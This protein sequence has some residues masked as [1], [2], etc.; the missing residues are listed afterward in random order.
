MGHAV[1]IKALPEASYELRAVIGADEA[2][3]FWQP[4]TQRV[5]GDGSLLAGLGGGEGDS[6]AVVRVDEGE[7]AAAQ[8]IAQAHHGIA[9]KHFKQLMLEAFGFAGDGFA[10]AA[11][12]QSGGGVAHF[13]WIAGDNAADGGDAGQCDV[14]C[15][16]QGRSKTCS[17][18]LPRL[19]NCSRSWRI[20]LASIGAVAVADAWGRRVWQSE[21]RGRRRLGVL[22]PAI[23]R[24]AA[25]IEG[26]TGRGCAMIR[27]E[28][29]CFEALLSV[30]GSPLPKMP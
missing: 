20:S 17:L 14:C 1:G 9:G 19:G 29:E 11:G 3:R 10:A 26:I 16:H 30:F 25:D 12:A 8:S 18:A 21:L 4:L 24:S 13:V 2:R 5:K 7:Q 6:E 28:T 27:E 22:F 23:K 15:L